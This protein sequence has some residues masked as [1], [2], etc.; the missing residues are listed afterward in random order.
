MTDQALE[1]AIAM[2]VQMAEK[3]ATAEEQIKEYKAKMQRAE[4]FIADW[5]EFSGQKVAAPKVEEEPRR[6]GIKKRTTLP[7]PSNSKKEEVADVAREVLLERG[8]P[9]GRDD[10][11]AAV[12][13]RGITIHGKKPQVVFQTMMWRMQDVI[14]NIKGHGYWPADEDFPDGDYYAL[15]GQKDEREPED[16]EEDVDL[17][18]ELD[19]DA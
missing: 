1:N 17:S 6:G 19:E 3:I 8:K 11:F 12:S 16:V 2:R 10:L 4:R 15:I 18:A 9:M 5:E 13:D 14:V 7:R